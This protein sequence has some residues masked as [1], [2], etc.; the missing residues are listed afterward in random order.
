[1]SLKKKKK[2]SFLVVFISPHVTKITSSESPVLRDFCEN[3]SLCASH[4]S[5]ER[6][7]NRNYCF[8]FAKKKIAM[9]THGLAV[10]LSCTIK[11]DTN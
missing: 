9:G 10:S 11:F 2:K 8:Y 7:A 6:P 5:M 3:Y 4:P 1:M